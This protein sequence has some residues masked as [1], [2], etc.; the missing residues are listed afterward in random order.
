MASKSIMLSSVI[1]CMEFQGKQG[2]TVRVAATLTAAMMN[3]RVV[4]GT[5]VF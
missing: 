5:G 1:K 2:P 4:G 3:R